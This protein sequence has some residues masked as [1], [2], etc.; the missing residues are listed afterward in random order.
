MSP[1]QSRPPRPM[2]KQAHHYKSLYG[3]V[4][5]TS[6]WMWEH[7]QLSRPIPTPPPPSLPPR[8][9]LSRPFAVFGLQ[10]FTIRQHSP[11]SPNTNAANCRWSRTQPRQPKLPYYPRWNPQTGRISQGGVVH[12]P[13]CL[14]VGQ[15]GKYGEPA[16]YW[17]E[18]KGPLRCQHLAQCA[19]WLDIGVSR[20]CSCVSRHVRLQNLSNILVF[21][22][23]RRVL[24]GTLVAWLPLF[25]QD[26]VFISTTLNIVLLPALV[27]GE[28]SR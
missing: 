19:E 14:V 18:L 20:Y 21:L 4:V 11:V 16:P 28:E 15:N 12:G 8:C 3:R 6:V 2:R 7:L 27:K 23:A 17:Y 26:T 1:N 22:N 25:P 13:E 24:G 5:T 10:L 9:D